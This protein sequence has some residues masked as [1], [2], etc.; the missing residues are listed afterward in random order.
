MS[1]RRREDATCSWARGLR[2]VCS[3]L[4]LILAGSASLWGASPTLASKG[5]GDVN[6]IRLGSLDDVQPSLTG[7]SFFL[8]GNGTPTASFFDHH[9]DQVSAAP[10]VCAPNTALTF[11]NYKIWKLLDSATYNFAKR[12][13]NGY[14][15]ISVTDGAIVGNAY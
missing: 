12:P 6:I 2:R 11:S 4:V 9:I 8:Q 1:C 15:L 13:S 10:E 14:Y 5:G 3:V 7:P